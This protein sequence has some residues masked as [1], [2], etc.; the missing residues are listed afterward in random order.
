MSEAEHKRFVAETLARV[1]ASNSAYS[2]L[3]EKWKE[4]API[5]LP[6]I[7]IGRPMPPPEGRDRRP[8]WILCEAGL[9]VVCQCTDCGCTCNESCPKYEADEGS[10]PWEG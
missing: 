4:D 9:G 6:C 7:H 8:K 2:E 10:T 1:A 3:A 5:P